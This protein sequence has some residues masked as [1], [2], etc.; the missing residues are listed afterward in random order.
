MFCERARICIARDLE[1]PPDD[2]DMFFIIDHCE[3]AIK[4]SVNNEIVIA[5][6]RR[7]DEEAF[8]DGYGE[9]VVD[10]IFSNQYPF[11]NFVSSMLENKE[12]G[13]YNE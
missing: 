1:V 12:Y 9:E 8:L 11:T 6:D 5:F 3:S 7:E 4:N 13:E 10:R 2:I